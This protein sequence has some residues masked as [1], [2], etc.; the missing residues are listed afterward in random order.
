MCLASNYLVTKLL[1]KK[2]NRF[3]CEKLEKHFVNFV[4]NL[5]INMEEVTKI[6]SKVKEGLLPPKS[7]SL[8]EEAYCSY[9]KWCVKRNI[10]E[11]TE[12]TILAYFDTELAPYKAST[13]WT[14]YSMLRTTIKLHEKV[15]ISKFGSIICFLK[16]KGEAYKPKKSLTLSR[17]HVET[18]LMNAGEDHLL[19]KVG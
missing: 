5:E 11:T 9:R 16:R 17:E 10:V 19:N 13:L 18:F 15:D 3:H 4:I 12:D 7:K 2:T 14:K 8:Y 1:T 6:A